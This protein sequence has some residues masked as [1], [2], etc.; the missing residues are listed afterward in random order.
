ME[1]IMLELDTLISKYGEIGVFHII[2]NWEQYKGICQEPLSIEDRWARFIS[3]T[4]DNCA[5]FTQVVSA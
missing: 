2:E 1:L 4:N 3:E 5:P